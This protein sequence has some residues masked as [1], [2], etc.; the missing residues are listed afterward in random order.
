MVKVGEEKTLFYESEADLQHGPFHIKPDKRES[1]SNSNEVP[2]KANK[3]GPK[4]KLKLYLV[5][6]LMRTS[7]GTAKGRNVL[8]KKFVRYL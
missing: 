8:A 5:E 3:V 4:Y 7:Y 1:G 2:L 6:E